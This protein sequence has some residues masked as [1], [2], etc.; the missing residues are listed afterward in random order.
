MKCVVLR[1]H[2]SR[3]RREQRGTVAIIVALSALVLF[4][5]AGIA[6]DVGRLYV[7]KTELQTAA[8]ACALAASAELT[9]DPGAGV[10]PVSFLLNAQAAG[11]F[12]AGRNVRDARQPSSLKTS[13]D[14][15]K[16]AERRDEAERDR[17]CNGPPDDNLSARQ[18]RCSGGDRRCLR[19]GP[20]RAAKLPP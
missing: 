10:C 9:C 6:I 17:P 7:N 13:F 3:G 11:I 14:E 4:G 16:T 12:A 15:R 20:T 2:R 8:D 19:V 18:Q 5:F 1:T